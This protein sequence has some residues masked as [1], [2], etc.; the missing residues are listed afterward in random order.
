MRDVPEQ[1]VT[2]GMVGA[3]IE[4]FDEPRH[5]YEAELVDAD[6][7]SIMQ[8]TLTDEDLEL[9]SAPRPPPAGARR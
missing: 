6:G 3:V 2:R 9:V 8:A 1:R 4:V 5:A 7:K